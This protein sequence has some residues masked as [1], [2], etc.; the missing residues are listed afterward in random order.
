MATVDSTAATSTR[1]KT[2]KLGL[3]VVGTAGGF[4]AGEAIISNTAI[5]AV[6]KDL[7]MSVFAQTLATSTFTLMLAATIMAFGSVSDRFGR[8][9]GFYLGFTFIIIGDL[10][11]ASAQAPWWFILG[12]AVSG[13]GAGGC[14]ATGFSLVKT[15]T[16]DPKRLGWAVGLYMSC[17]FIGATMLSGIGGVANNINWRL[18]FLA[19]PLLAAVLLLLAFR[20]VPEAFGEH[21]RKFDVVGLAVLALAMVTGLFGL[22]QATTKLYAISTWALIVV[23]VIA[24]VSF[25]FIEK[26][27]EHPAFPVSLLKNRIFLAALVGG[28]LWNGAESTTLLQSSY[29]FQYIYT[30]PPFTTVL[31][32]APLTV[33]AIV[34]A[35][36]VGRQLTKGRSPR[37]IMMFGAACLAL[38]FFI[39]SFAGL[40]SSYW[41]FGPA[42]AIVGV[43]MVCIATPQA[44]MFVQQAPPKFLGPVAASRAASGQLGYAI[45]LAAST[46]ILSFFLSADFNRALE[47]AHVPPASRQHIISSAESMLFKD[48]LATTSDAKQILAGARAEYVAAYGSVMFVGV[49]II[50]VLALVIFVLLR[51][52]RRSSTDA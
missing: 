35:I 37:S 43:G 8:R 25:Y 52:T 49:G 21:R 26:A 45:G 36:I 50:I 27:K 4:A 28:M 18:A 48:D 11:A 32:Q 16:P 44:E 51:N 40:D 41:L 13:I 17:T 5:V 15:I 29:L 14:L 34:A 20:S 23:S 7:G 46:A 24:F 30:L 3:I 22:S 39:F 6:S 42:F 38:G 9:R 10:L 12:R 47:R 2:P 19:P 33:T 1:T 31:A